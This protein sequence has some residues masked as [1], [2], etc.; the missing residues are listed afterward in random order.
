MLNFQRHKTIIELR[1]N[2]IF[3]SVTIVVIL[4]AC[5]NLVFAAPSSQATQLRHQA[6][7]QSFKG[8]SIDDAGI[9]V[10]VIGVGIVLRV[11]FLIGKWLYEN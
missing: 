3:S 1:K 2:A 9:I 5:S 10:A 4:T 8:M 11:L 6:L 7:E